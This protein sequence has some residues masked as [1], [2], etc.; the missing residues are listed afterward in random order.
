MRLGRRTTTAVVAGGAAV[1][2]AA[3][4]A[5]G[6]DQPHLTSVA[7]ANEKAAGVSAPNIVSPEL[8]DVLVAQGSMKL[9]GG[10]SAVPYYG[11][12]GNGTL[13]PAFNSNAEATKTEPDKNTYL[14]FDQGLSGPDTGYDYGTHFLFQGHELGGPGYITRINLDA[15][16][17]H[18]V[19]LMSTKT[20]AGADLKTIDGSMWN[21]F[22]QKLLYTT[23]SGSVSSVY[24]ATPGYPSHVVDVSNVFG[25]GAFEG[26]QAD[27]RG[28]LYLAED[29]GGKVGAVSGDTT[30]KNAFTK[31]PNSFIY[32][33]LP[34]DPSDLSK[35]GKMQ[36]LQVLVNGQPVKFTM[37]ASSS[38]ADVAAAANTDISGS[39]SAGYVALHTYGTSYATKWVTIN[40]TTSS[41]ALPGADDNAL[42]KAAGGTPFKRPE[43]GV[44][45][46]GSRFKELYFDETGDTDNRTCAGG[47]ST[48]P[49]CTT[50]NLTGGFGSLFKLVQSPTSDDGT[51]T[52]LYNGDQTHAGFDNT[53]F[54]SRNQVVFVEDAGDT[55]HAQ[56][57]A[58]DS[59]W[60]FDVNA[61]YAHGAQPTRIIA[62]GRDASATIDSGLSGSAGFQNEGDNEITGFYVSDG[63]ASTHGLLGRNDPSL[64]SRSSD[65]RAFWTQ[66]HG[67]NNTWELIAA[68]GGQPGP[69]D[70][71]DDQD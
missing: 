27:E 37:P 2:A 7:T 41:T 49:S 42:A 43:N 6:P 34:N 32:R 65:S 10:T 50:P 38:A 20:D 70:D 18:R 54:V 19:T 44:F 28:N 36:V 45:R 17:A 63:D 4:L 71:N 23:E 33:F 56:R 48:Q 55:L 40:T 22:T 13:L 16:G 52:V 5:L 35:G 25:R 24:E 67:D 29:A 3:A 62:E 15:D 66:Q 59:A 9:D 14:V 39:N 68:P 60:L 8:A 30:S 51:I 1:A 64:F 61:D 26:V 12:D 46:P 31:Q 21:P 69:S 58:L 47:V 53:A 57:N 11:Y